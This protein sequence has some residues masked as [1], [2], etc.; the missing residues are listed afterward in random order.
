MTQITPLILHEPLTVQLIYLLRE[1]VCAGLDCLAEGFTDLAEERYT[2]A[3]GA[4]QLWEAAFYTQLR[5]L[6]EAER[7]QVDKTL[8]EDLHRLD[9]AISAHYEQPLRQVAP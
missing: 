2:E 1:K 8:N 4:R 5:D 9:D 6:T 3:M 7:A